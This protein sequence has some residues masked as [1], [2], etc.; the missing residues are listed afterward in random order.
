MNVWRIYDDYVF[1]PI[2]SRW[3]KRDRVRWRFAYA[4]LTH[5]LVALYEAT[6]ATIKQKWEKH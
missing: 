1:T 4:N 5:N 3:N 2:T 6:Q